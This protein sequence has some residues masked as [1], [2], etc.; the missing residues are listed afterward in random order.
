MNPVVMGLLLVGLW[1]FF[2]VSAVRRLKLL[3][4]GAPTHEPRTDRLRPGLPS[5]ASMMAPPTASRDSAAT[6]RC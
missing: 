6:D 4:S 5:C 1:G 2:A 3:R